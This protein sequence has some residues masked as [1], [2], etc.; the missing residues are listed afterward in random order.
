MLNKRK[1]RKGECMTNLFSG[2]SVFC[3]LF[4]EDKFEGYGLVAEHGLGGLRRRRIGWIWSWWPRVCD[5]FYC[6]RPRGNYLQTTCGGAEARYSVAGDSWSAVAENPEM[7]RTPLA[8]VSL[9]T[10]RILRQ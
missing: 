1:T 7:G 8:M 3:R 2:F 6:A 10:R 5:C 9:V 4:E